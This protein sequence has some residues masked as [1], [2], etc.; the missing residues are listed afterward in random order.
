MVTVMASTMAVPNRP[1]EGFESC[2]RGRVFTAMALASAGDQKPNL[3]PG[4]ARPKYIPRDGH[5][6]RGRP[7]VNG[8][9]APRPPGPPIITEDVLRDSLSLG[10]D[11]G[12]SV[13]IGE[14]L[15][16]HRSIQ[17]LDEFKLQCSAVHRFLDL[18]SELPRMT[19]R[20]VSLTVK[21][22][23]VV[24]PYRPTR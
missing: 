20:I 8:T 2:G 3:Q 6:A 14:Q 11:N 16:R 21:Q 4:G 10:T 12:R 22:V 19:A 24:A 1:I 7:V 15:R 18:E 13:S 23:A 9:P 5:R 17:I